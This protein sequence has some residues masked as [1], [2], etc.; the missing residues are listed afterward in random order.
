MQISLFE[1]VNDVVIPADTVYVIPWLKAVREN[2]PESYLKV[3][4]YLFFMS[5]WDGRNAYINR[6]EEEREQAIIEAMEIDF[7]LDDP[8]IIIALEKCRQLYETPGV[9]AFKTIKNKIDDICSFLDD[10]K[11]ISGKN[12]NAQD[13]KMF[14]KELPGFIEDYDKLDFRLKEEQSRVRGMKQLAYDQQID[15]NK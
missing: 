15:I 12:G 9:R 11:T 14:M 8:I 10:N 3:Y 2:Y 13:V 5:C 1:I 4:G 7:S 6:P